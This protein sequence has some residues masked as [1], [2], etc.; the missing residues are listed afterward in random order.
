M[1]IY[2]YQ[3]ENCGHEFEKLVRFSDPQN[4][5]P[6]C[7]GCNSENTRKRLSAI[8]AFSAGQ[9]QS[10]GQL[11]QFRALSLRGLAHIRPAVWKAQ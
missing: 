4:T 6:E 3:C 10:G 7:P 2:E 5:Q 11:W 8:A 1:P 9:T